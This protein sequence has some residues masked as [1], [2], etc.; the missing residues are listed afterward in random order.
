[1]AL[2]QAQP[3][4]IRIYLTRFCRFPVGKLSGTKGKPRDDDKLPESERGS[5][6]FLAEWG[7][8]VLVRVAD[9]LYQAVRSESA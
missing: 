4:Q 8:V 7:H 1:M 9:F 3:R 5:D 6:D 2:P